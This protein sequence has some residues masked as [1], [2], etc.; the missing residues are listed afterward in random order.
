MKTSSRDSRHAAHV[1]TLQE[2]FDKWSDKTYGEKYRAVASTPVK[3]PTT[4]AGLL[5]KRNRGDA[6]GGPAKRKLYP[7]SQS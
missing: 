1:K 7:A 6:L 4:F 2:C 5:D 3:A